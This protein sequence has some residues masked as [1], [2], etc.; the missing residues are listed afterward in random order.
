MIAWSTDGEGS[1]GSPAAHIR[2]FQLSQN[3]LSAVHSRYDFIT[4]MQDEISRPVRPHERQRE[5]IET[6]IVAEYLRTFFGCDA[7]I[8]KSSMQRDDAE[9]NRNLVILHRDLFV[10]NTD[11][12]VVSYADW[13]LLDVV[14]VRYSTADG[15]PL[16]F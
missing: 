6:Q 8:H 3:S 13:L 10:G 12:A 1:I 4:Q 14:D 9:D 16:L 15:T 11:P 7:V 5:Y 2:S